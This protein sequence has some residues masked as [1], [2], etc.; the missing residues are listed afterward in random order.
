MKALKK[1]TIVPYVIL[2]VLLLVWLFPIIS[3]LITVIKTPAFFDEGSFWQ[4]PS[5]EESVRGVVENFS[6]A[7]T[8]SQIGSNIL[9]SLL[10]AVTAGL[11][12]G[13]VASLAAFSLTQL[14]LAHP[15]FWFI[16]IFIGNLFPFQLFLIPLYLFL[17]GLGLY[18]TRLGLSIVYIGICV[19]FALFIY[20]NYA[21]TI[22][23]AIFDSARI[24]GASD[25]VLFLRIFLP[26]SRP[27]L[28]VI[29]TFQ[30]IWTWNDLL[31]GLVLAESTRPAMTALSKLTGLRTG[32][33]PTVTLAGA[34]M[35]AIPATIIL[36]SLQRYFVRGFTINLEK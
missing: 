28:M 21:F 7:F 16:L 29:F 1:T 34:I 14:N 24:D 36:F 3:S 12:S 35:A 15:Q 13:L 30:F 11:L 31:F 20:R 6:R 26:V 23:K 2:G 8:E 33:P 32:T 10:F 18:D 27:A 25:Y 9:N 17:N 5:L 4:L 19:P 22:P